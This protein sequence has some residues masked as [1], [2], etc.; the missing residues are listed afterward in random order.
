MRQLE[1]HR[2]GGLAINGVIFA[3]LSVPALDLDEVEQLLL[4]FG[5][6]L[7]EIP[8][9]GLF[10]AGKAFA[11]YRASGGTKSSPLPD[12]FI[13]AHAEASSLPLITRDS[14]RYRTYFPT[15]TLITPDE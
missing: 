2:S 7:R 6:V 10:L 8:R 15:V 12:F 14:A 5:L 3:E 13:G 4:A 1:E 11:R 9:P